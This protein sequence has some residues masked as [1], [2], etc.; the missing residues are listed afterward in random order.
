VLTLREVFGD[1][2]KKRLVYVGD[3]NNVAAS[4]AVIA[5]QLEF[6][7]TVCTPKDYALSDEFLADLKKRFPTAAVATSTDPYKAVA[8]A[9]VIYTDVWASMGQEAEADKRQKDFAPYQINAKLMA[10]S[11]ANCRFMH[12]LP[13]RRGIEVTDDVMDSPQSIVFEQAEN[14]MHLA[15]GLMVWLI[16]KKAS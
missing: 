3:G 8:N 6:A 4:L 7:M 2:N 5:A 15:K 11:P 14:R 1:L 12:C 9:D 16:E 10:A 13:A